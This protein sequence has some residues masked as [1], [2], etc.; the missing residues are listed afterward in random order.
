MYAL[1]NVKG[2]EQCII[3]TWYNNN[4]ILFCV[5]NN[6]NNIINNNNNNNNNNKGHSFTA[7]N[8]SKGQ[9]LLIHANSS[10][11][12]VIHYLHAVGQMSGAIYQICNGS[13]G[14][15]NLLTLYLRSKGKAHSLNVFLRSKGKG[16]LLTL[17]LRSKSNCLL[18]AIGQ[19]G[20]RL[21]G[22]NHYKLLLS[23]YRTNP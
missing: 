10:S 22:F 12:K 21:R 18:L 2:H 17:Y 19:K 7:C 6:N 13:N 11:G 9:A 16:H 3:Q 20:N 8:I 23:Q 14:K 15:G 5:I 1:C 4:N